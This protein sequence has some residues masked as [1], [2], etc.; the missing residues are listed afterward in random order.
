MWEA[1]KYQLDNASTKLGRTRVLR[2]FTAAQP[3]PDEMVTQYFSKLIASNNKLIGTTENITDDTMKTPIFT[4]QSNSYETII[5]IL[6]QRIPAPTA[7]QCIDAISEHAELTTLP[8]EFGDPSTRAGLY[9]RGGNRGRGSGHGRGGQGG[10]SG[11]GRGNGRLKHQCTFC[12]MDNHTTEECGKRKNTES[13]TNTSRNDERTCFYCGPT[14]RF[15]ADCVHINRARDQRNKVDKGTA[16]PSLATIADRDL[17]GLAANATALTAASAP[18]AWVID[19]GASHHMCNDRTRFNWIKKPCQPLVI[20]LGDDNNVTISHH[21]LVDVSHIYDVNVRYMPTFWLSL[22]SINQ[23]DT[24][25]YTSTFGHGKC[26]ISS[27]S[28]RITG[29]V[30]NGSGPSLPVWVRVQTGP[31]PNWQSGSS[32]NPNSPFRYCSM[33]NSQPV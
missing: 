17:I 19:S 21:G 18:A 8:N 14:G 30:S 29:S 7:Q 33:E 5:Q 23:L 10:G 26:S 11:C 1:L 32:I 9:S 3:S 25:G 12:K 31:L 20:E 15:E 16:S 13:D 6:E 2:K 28:I 4:T 22:L 24:A 27:P